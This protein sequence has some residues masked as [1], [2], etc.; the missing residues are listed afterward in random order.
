MLLRIYIIHVFVVSVMVYHLRIKMIKTQ[1]NRKLI[2]ITS[3]YNLGYLPFSL[4]NHDRTE[5][6]TKEYVVYIFR[7]SL[8]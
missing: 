4:R 3:S 7:L 5:K 6:L 2:E 1:T 8:R